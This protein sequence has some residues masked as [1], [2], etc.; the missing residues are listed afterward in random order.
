MKDEQANLGGPRPSS[1][2][3]APKSGAVGGLA[4]GWPQQCSIT[5]TNGGPPAWPPVSAWPGGRPIAQW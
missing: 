1:A 2:K 3:A 5:R 4:P